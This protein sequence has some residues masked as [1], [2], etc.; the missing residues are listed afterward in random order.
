MVTP[1]FPRLPTLLRPWPHRQVVHH[2]RDREI[3]RGRACVASLLEKLNLTNDE[4]EVAAFSDDED[5]Q[6]GVIREWS[7]IGK[8]L[9]PATLHISTI[10]GGNPYGVKLQSVG[11]RSE[12]LFIVVFRRQ[13]AMIH[14]LEG[15]PWMVG[16]HAVIL[17]E[18]DA[19]LKPSDV[20]FTKMKMWVR[21]LNLPF[22]WMEEKH[23]VRVASLIGKVVRVEAGSDGKVSGPY[24]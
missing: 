21:I 13:D 20:C 15:S 24:L 17:R 7:L 1:L 18:Y 4:G 23:G 16:K 19:T 11:K 10:T 9:S 3:A 5:V 2:A 14:A 6:D 22:G 8:V 12:N